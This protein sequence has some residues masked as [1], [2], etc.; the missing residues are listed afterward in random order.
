MG[1]ALAGCGQPRDERPIPSAAPST[2]RTM[3][4][5]TAS[6]TATRTLRSEEPPRADPTSERPTETPSEVPDPAPSLVGDQRNTWAFAP[7]ED[8]GSLVVEG[9]VPRQRAW[10]TSKVLVVAAYLEQRGA[11]S[12]DALSEADADAVRRALTESHMDSLLRLRRQLADRSGQMTRI[13]REIGDDETVVPGTREGTMIWTVAQQ[14]RFMAALAHGRV[15]N[16]EVSAL[17]LAHMTPIPSQRWGLGTIDA[18]AYKGGWLTPQSETRQ[19][20]IVG[21]HAVAILTHGV[22]PA[23]LQSD[24]DYAHVRQMNDLA[25]QLR[26]R[27]SLADGR[28]GQ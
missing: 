12:L 2:A 21:D 20:G 13:L 8:L 22:G 25:E 24:A 23:E 28:A 1:L 5:A 15:V 16:P 3:P 17:L 10:S 6:P 4:T 11:A 9:E 7:L 26:T 18:S 19:M 27:L 14:V